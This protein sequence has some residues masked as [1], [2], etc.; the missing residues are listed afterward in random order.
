[1]VAKQWP[2]G[3]GRHRA[4]SLNKAQVTMEDTR[5][6]QKRSLEHADVD[7]RPHSNRVLCVSLCPAGPSSGEL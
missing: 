1:M 5:A 3:N 4:L 2:V 6:H 7:T